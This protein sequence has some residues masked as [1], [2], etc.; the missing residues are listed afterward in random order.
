MFRL[1]RA[2]KPYRDSG[3]L[4][5]QVNLFGFIGNGV[6]LTKSGDVG[7]MLAVR[8][9]DY[10][11]LAASEIDQYTKRLESA[12]KIFDEKCRVYQYLFKRNHERIPCSSHANPV[13]NAA[14]QNRAAFLD[15]KSDHLYSLDICYA[16]LMEGLPKQKA[17]LATL[18]E[19][20]RDPRRAWREVSALLSTEKQVLLLG[21]ELARLQSALRQKAQ[22]FILQVNDFLE[23]EILD[24][25]RAFAALKRTLNFSPLKLECARLS[26]I[27]SSTTTCRSR[28][29]NATAV[30]C[31][32][33]IIT[34]KSSR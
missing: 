22:N 15:A 17:F 6:F 21:S 10:E 19:A 5:D 3:S 33:M 2:L 12:F 30:S 23:A 8:G 28:T 26:T 18:T 24:K 13:A 11:G 32:W 27:P 25:Q 16:V 4:N 14:I 29:W 34:S 9:V 31:G 20:Y 7:L 1:D